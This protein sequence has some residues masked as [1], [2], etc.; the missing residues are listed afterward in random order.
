MSPKEEKNLILARIDA[1]ELAKHI[2]HDQVTEIDNRIF[3]LKN[4][5]KI[6]EGI[7]ASGDMEMVDSDRKPLMAVL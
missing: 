6:L 2:A 5:L 7:K 3:E 4:E 1:F